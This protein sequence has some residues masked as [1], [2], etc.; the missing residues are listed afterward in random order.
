MCIIN[1]FFA[2]KKI[3]EIF[4]VDIKRLVI[5]IMTKREREK[6]EREREK[7]IEDCLNIQKVIKKAF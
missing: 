3:L 7:E 4:L 1:I 2:Y 6:K 5:Y